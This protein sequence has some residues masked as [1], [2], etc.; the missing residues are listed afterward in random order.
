MAVTKTTRV[1]FVFQDTDLNYYDVD[2]DLDTGVGVARAHGSTWKST[3]MFNATETV[4]T[5][6]AGSL[7]AW[8]GY[9]NSLR[10]HAEVYNTSQSLNDIL[11][12]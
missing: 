4:I 11:T 12:A 8:Q 10:I 2:I 3:P 6:D 1:R 5:V 9:D 7:S